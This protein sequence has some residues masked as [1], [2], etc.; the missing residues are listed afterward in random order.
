MLFN[1]R[2]LVWVS[3]ARRDVAHA[4]RLLRRNPILAI[5]TTVSLAIGI[6]A[7]TTVFTVANA[8]LFQF[9]AGTAADDHNHLITPEERLQ[10]A[11][12]RQ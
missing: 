12:A 10:V 5:T 8:L 1:T 6:G 2:S 4:A 3:D 7:N 11:M 9:D